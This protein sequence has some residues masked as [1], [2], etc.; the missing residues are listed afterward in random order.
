M[1]AGPR[2]S[3]KFHFGCSAVTP[4]GA[5]YFVWDSKLVGFGL[6]IQPT[7]VMTY[8]AKYRAGLVTTNVY[9]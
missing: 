9:H 8:V 7:G 5:E 3:P 2:C 6:R 1:H 4:A